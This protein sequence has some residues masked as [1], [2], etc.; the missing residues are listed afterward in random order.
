MQIQSISNLYRFSTRIICRCYWWGTRVNAHV[1]TRTLMRLA[2]WC[3]ILVIRSLV[4]KWRGYD[5][6]KVTWD[7]GMISKLRSRRDIILWPQRQRTYRR[8]TS[9]L[10]RLSFISADFFVCAASEMVLCY[11]CWVLNW[12]ASK[13]RMSR[14]EMSCCFCLGQMRGLSVFS[15]LK[16]WRVHALAPTWTREIVRKPG[17][18]RKVCCCCLEQINRST[19]E[20]SMPCYLESVGGILRCFRLSPWAPYLQLLNRWEALLSI[21]SWTSER[22]LCFELQYTVQTTNPLFWNCIDLELMRTLRV[23]EKR[24]VALVL[25]LCWHNLKREACF[26]LEP[27]STLVKGFI[28]EKRSRDVVLH[29]SHIFLTVCFWSW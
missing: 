19:F 3:S 8:E 11:A 28:N 25:R 17:N 1:T 12:W 9:S 24:P 13:D 5:S 21:W 27:L 23:C 7:T 20:I 6:A 14:W 26:C 2:F 18:G 15:T 10:R 4:S 22:S 16:P 29:E